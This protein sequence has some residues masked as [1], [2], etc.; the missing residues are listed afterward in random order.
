M[1]QITDTMPA[2]PAQVNDGTLSWPTAAGGRS[3]D[4]GRSSRICASRAVRDI[5]LLVWLLTGLLL[6]IDARGQLVLD[7]T[8]APRDSRTSG[9]VKM[10]ITSSTRRP[11]LPLEIHIRD[12]YP[13]TAA[14]GDRLNVLLNLR[15]TGKVPFSIPCSRDFNQLSDENVRD[16][17]QLSIALQLLEDQ[18]PVRILVGAFAGAPSVPGSMCELQPGATM[19]I[20]GSGLISGQQ[21]L[22]D[23]AAAQTTLNLKGVVILHDYDA[24]HAEINYSQPAISSDS[25]ALYYLGRKPKAQ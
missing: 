20:R 21:R 4:P 17:R 23:P 9:I 8:T 25:V 3:S 12:L 6:C 2:L 5:T 16:E 1:H 14:Y 19:L 10:K 11:V 22:E 18:I 15:N 24:Q 7:A 13:V